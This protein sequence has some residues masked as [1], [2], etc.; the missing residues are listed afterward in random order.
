MRYLTL[1]LALPFIM[2][3]VSCRTAPKTPAEIEA[4]EEKAWRK[5]I[6]RL[7]TREQQRLK[8]QGTLTFEEEGDAKRLH[9]LAQHAWNKGDVRQALRYYAVLGSRYGESYEPAGAEAHLAIGDCFMKLKEYR[10]AAFSYKS[11]ITGYPQGTRKFL[12]YIK[13]GDA[14]M[15]AENYD[16]AFRAYFMAKIIYR[17]AAEDQNIQA[18]ID[19]AREAHI[20]DLENQA[21]AAADKS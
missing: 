3:M 15:A 5:Q 9:V 18:K 13:L 16:R 8:R 4:Q 12:G 19:R 10:K 1:L 21:K 14:Y 20:K 7:E 11:A 6:K 2:T 17:E